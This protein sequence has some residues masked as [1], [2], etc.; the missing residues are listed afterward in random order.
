M[1]DV[2]KAKKAGTDPHG[3]GISS[4]LVKNGAPSTTTGSSSLRT[5]GKNSR[6]GRACP[7]LF[8]GC[9]KLPAVQLT[10]FPDSKLVSGDRH[11]KPH[12]RQKHWIGQQDTSKVP[13]LASVTSLADYALSTDG[14]TTHFWSP[15]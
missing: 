3:F 2:I 10:C 14:N 12:A 9:W 4:R 13:R 11:L 7:R 5:Q 8:M 6:D 1:A 15:A